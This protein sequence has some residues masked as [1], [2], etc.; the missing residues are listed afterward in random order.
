[1]SDESF[2]VSK[3]DA[4]ATGIVAVSIGLLL[5]LLKGE[6]LSVLLTVLGVALLVKAVTELTRHNCFSA[7]VFGIAG[8]ITVVLGWALVSLAL[9]VLAAVL[10]FY[11][12]SELVSVSRA[13]APAEFFVRPIACLVFSLCL[14]VGQAATLN[15]M[16]TVV[17]VLFIALGGYEIYLSAK[18]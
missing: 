5:I 15:W 14:I 16:L 6:L 18:Q 12:I 1:M 13:K 4:M 10:L 11:A 7:T 2:S 3:K 8:L 9:Y 17:G